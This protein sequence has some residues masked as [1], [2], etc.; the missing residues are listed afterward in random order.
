MVVRLIIVLFFFSVGVF[1]QEKFIR[2]KI[3][4]GENLSVIAKKYG[5]KTKDIEEANPD[6]PKVLKLNSVLLI[7]NTNKKS[8][9]K[10][11]EAVASTIPATTLNSDIHE[12]Q[13]KETLWSISK[14]YNV[15]VE[16]LKKANPALE[17][18]GLK[19][20]QKLNIASN[21]IASTQSTT[22]NQNIE[23]PELI[24]STD[25][26]VVVEVKPKETKYLIAKK[27]GITVAEL[28]RQNPYIKGK[29][30]VGYVL[31][32]KTSKEKADIAQALNT[33]IAEKAVVTSENATATGDL[34][35]EIVS[36]NNNVDIVVEVQP[37]ETKFAIA[38]RYGLTVAEL[39]RQNPFIKGKLPVG[40]VL[41]INTSKEKA[42]AAQ[43]LNTTPQLENNSSS[44]T[45]VAD[46]SEIRKDTTTIFRV[47]NH[48]ELVNQLIM[49]AT[50]NIGT[51]YRSGGTTKA[52]FDCSGLM[53]CTFNN[54]D[55]KLPRSSIEQ[56]RIGTK[57]D[58]DEAQKGD[59]IFFK[60]NG[61]RQINHVGM[62]VEVADGEIKFVHSS[63]HGGVMISSTK[64]AYYQRTFSQVNR[65][66][67]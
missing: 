41:K 48:S 49:N 45:Q 29:L 40:Y 1:S 4:K 20:G 66:L 10:K 62:V 53:I 17:N 35:P 21:T 24:S 15:T 60:T 42:D 43:V 34:K 9:T 26:E 31:K 16:D 55:I 13:E 5:V 32:I 57:V 47:S 38:K 59:L 19:I 64:E 44:P 36:A 22:K 25:V 37:K 46:N 39:E 28:E 6:A 27:Y 52:G 30:P 56:S 2:H 51:R 65:I 50:E 23:K 33:Q 67:Q 7:P 12:V 54:F 61:R 18:D 58:T 63:T 3:S 14:K 11:T 8:T